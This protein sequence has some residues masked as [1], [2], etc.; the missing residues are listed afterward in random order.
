MAE[1]RTDG[2]VGEAVTAL[3]LVDHHVHQALGGVL[4]RAGFEHQITESDRRTP[5]GTTQFDSQVSFAVRRW[6]APVLGLPPTSR[7]AGP[8]PAT[9]APPTPSGSP[10]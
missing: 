6:C 3:A 5:A 9:G 8:R 7:A 4:S 10:R 1:H 2:A